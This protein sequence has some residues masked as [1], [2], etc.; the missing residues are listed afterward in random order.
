MIDWDPSNSYTAVC[1]E[2]NLN[3][4]DAM[5]EMCS[6]RAHGGDAADKDAA[7]SSLTE[8]A[9]SSKSQANNRCSANPLWTDEAIA[10]AKE[11][12]KKL[13]SWSAVV[14]PMTKLARAKGW[15]F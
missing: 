12:Y 13:G 9:R 4:A 10:A 2:N 7:D 8:A 5:A 11:L 1:L 15:E 6:M 3:Q 14:A